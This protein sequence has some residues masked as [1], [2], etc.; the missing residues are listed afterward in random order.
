M[1]VRVRA[2]PPSSA[3][4]FGSLLDYGLMILSTLSYGEIT[5]QTV[6]AKSLPVGSGL[7]GHIYLTVLVAM[8][9]GKF[10]KNQV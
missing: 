1:Q 10:L 6:V 2:D 5:P 9:V 8:R 4:R 3:E 7:L